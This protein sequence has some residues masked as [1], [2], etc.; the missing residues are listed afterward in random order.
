MLI[1]T[2]DFGQ[3]EVSEENVL[4]FPK[5]LFG[6]EQI[7]RYVLL[8]YDLK[9]ESPIM[10]LQSIGG[11]VSFT[12]VDPF[13]FLPGYAPVVNAEELAVLKVQDSSQLRFLAVAVIG[14][15]MDQTVMNLKSPVALNPGNHLGMQII[16]SEGDYAQRHPLFLSEDVKKHV[17]G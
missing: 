10:C 1:Q 14:D 8:H 5:G 2:T 3:L 12:V 13:Y 4:F 9:E 16:L 7:N 11:E 17:G 6:F 15:S